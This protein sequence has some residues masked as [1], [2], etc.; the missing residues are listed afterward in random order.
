MQ[1]QRAASRDSAC[2]A[3]TEATFDIA[4]RPRGGS[5][6]PAL[7]CSTFALGFKLIS[8]PSGMLLPFLAARLQHST[9]AI[10]A[11]RA[12]AVPTEPPRS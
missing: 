9:H 2:E 12:F 6:P 5:A 3:P 10:K 8:S 4:K 11:C 7:A 1:M